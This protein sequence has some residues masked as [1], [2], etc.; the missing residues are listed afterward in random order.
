MGQRPCLSVERR[1][2]PEGWPNIAGGR[3]RFRPPG[4]HGTPTPGCSEQA[5]HLGGVPEA[6]RIAPRV[7]RFDTGP[8]ALVVGGRWRVGDVRLS[9][10]GQWSGDGIVTCL[11]PP[12]LLSPRSQ[13]SC[14]GGQPLGQFRSF[15]LHRAFPASAIPPGWYPVASFPEVCALL[16][17]PAKFSLPSGKNSQPLVPCPVL[18]ACESKSLNGNHE[19]LGCCE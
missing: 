13:V 14:G 8:C 6:D 10:G 15:L 18:L 7:V 2:I 11:L 5:S 4:P 19:S 3:R 12:R 17:P 9:I 1:P 16:R